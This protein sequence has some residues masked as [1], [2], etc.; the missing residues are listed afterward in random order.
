MSGTGRQLPKDV[1]IRALIWAP[2][3]F[4]GHF[5]N[6]QLVDEDKRQLELPSHARPQHHNRLKRLNLPNPPHPPPLLI[7]HLDRAELES[8]QKNLL[9]HSIRARLRVIP[10]GLSNTSAPSPTFLSPPL[11]QA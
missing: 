9:H 7:L 5:F 8:E 4:P 11:L 1:V 3:Y 2:S 6:G 10:S